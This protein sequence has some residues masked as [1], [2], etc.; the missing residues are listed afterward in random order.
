MTTVVGIKTNI[1]L[2]LNIL[3]NTQFKRGNYNIQ[4]LEKSLA[5]KAAKAKS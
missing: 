3:S 4:F 1:P 2:N 5:K